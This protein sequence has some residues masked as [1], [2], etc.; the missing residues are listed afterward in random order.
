MWVKSQAPPAT[1][2]SAVC[3]EVRL[4]VR[5]AQTMQL[6]Q[7]QWTCSGL[8]L[9]E[10]YISAATIPAAADLELRRS[11]KRMQENGENRRAGRA[12]L[13]HIFLHLC[14]IRGD[15]VRQ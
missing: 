10:I 13:A 11:E 4:A 14:I 1:V 8:L 15:V 7:L 9:S 5:W 12:K 3:Q 6:A 2:P